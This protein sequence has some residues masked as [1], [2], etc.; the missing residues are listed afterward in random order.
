MMNPFKAKPPIHV[1]GTIERIGL[2]SITG[3]YFSFYLKLENDHR[4]F[5][6]DSQIGDRGFTNLGLT[7]GKPGDSV[8]FAIPDKKHD[9]H[10]FIKAT[11]FFENRSLDMK[12]V[13]PF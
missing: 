6:I 7:T 11:D 13:G 12:T 3:D 1:E 10:S 5:R 4:W 8:R 9:E 2:A